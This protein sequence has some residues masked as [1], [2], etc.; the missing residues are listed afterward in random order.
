MTDKKENAK[1]AP[2]TNPLFRFLIFIVIAMGLVFISTGPIQSH[3]GYPPTVDTG[4]TVYRAEPTQSTGTA[5]GST[6]NM[7]NLAQ[8]WEIPG[9]A[10]STGD[11]LGKLEHAI[12]LKTNEERKRRNIPELKK[13]DGLARTARY[14]SGDMAQNNYFDHNNLDNLGPSFRRAKIHR[15]YI[16]TVGENIF[17]MATGKGNPEEIAEEIVRGWMNSTGHRENILHNSYNYLGVGCFETQKNNLLTIHATQVFG[18][19]NGELTTELPGELKPTQKQLIR[20]GVTTPEYA[21]PRAVTIINLETRGKEGTFK[22]SPADNLES[23]G[24]FDTPQAEG[25]YQL[26][27]H[28]PFA[29]NPNTL[30]SSRGPLFV[31][32]KEK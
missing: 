31:V 7:H 6:V 13:E 10:A 23:S 29:D 15:R 18:K 21:A 5:P 28:I 17:R 1:S 19:K 16:G 24:S 26:V 25:A 8:E 11:F 30:I 14:H 3:F 32:K 9:Q 4:E 22:L 20:V 2:E 12:F 27:F